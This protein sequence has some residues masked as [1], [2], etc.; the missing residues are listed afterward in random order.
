MST[1]SKSVYALLMSPFLL[2]LTSCDTVYSRSYSY[3]KTHFLIAKQPG[4]KTLVQKGYNF[5]PVEQVAL[6][7][8]DIEKEKRETER[9][10]MATQRSD[11]AGI[12]RMGTDSPALKLDSGLDS[13]PGLKMDSGLGSG[14][15]LSGMGGGTI[16]G[17][18]PSPAKS[19]SSM[20][21][22]TIP[23]LDSAPSMSGA[24]AMS[25]AP[26]MS[27]A[28]AMDGAMAPSMA[29]S[30]TPA[31]APGAPKPAATMLPGL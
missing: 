4:G 21:G 19:A 22:A 16:P 2:G 18:D 8:A 13:A 7:R 31:P 17:L 27:G 20:S 6:A 15:S 9:L 12:D 11:K 1:S 23:G 10:R 14:S 25:G 30:M 5:D 24:P 28:P 3:E 29:P 26:S